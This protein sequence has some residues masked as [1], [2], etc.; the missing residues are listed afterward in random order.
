MNSRN[1]ALL[2]D[3]KEGKKKQAKTLKEEEQTKQEEKIRAKKLNDRLVEKEKAC[4]I[5]EEELKKL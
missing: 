2:E 3:L 5:L 4:A 1:I